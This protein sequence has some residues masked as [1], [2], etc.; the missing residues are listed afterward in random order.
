MVLDLTCLA[1]R[2]AN[3]RSR[4]SASVGAR[5][6]TIFSVMSSTTALSRLCTSKPP[7]TVF[8]VRPAA[9]GSGR[10][11]A[12]SSRRFLLLRDDRDRLFGRIR[13]DDHFGEDF[14]DGARGIGI[15]RA[16]DRDDAAIGRLRIA[17]ERLAI[18][19]D[20]IGALGDAAGI[21]MLD[22]DAGRGARRIEFGDAFIGRIGVVDVVV[23]QFLALQLPRGG[24]ARDACRACDRTRRAGAGSRRS[25]APGS[26]GR[27]RRGNPARRS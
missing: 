1:T 27:R 15:Q 5:L 9:R 2:N 3:L 20:E 23:G 16:V 17:G 10:L 26:A 14:G 22:D 4:S 21:G 19:A 18:G 8:A 12:S 25:A 11:P 24:D 6:V 7:A 13:R